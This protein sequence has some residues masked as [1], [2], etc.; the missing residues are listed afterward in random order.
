MTD[1]AWDL[2]QAHCENG[3]TE[4]IL[5]LVRTQRKLNRFQVND[6]IDTMELAKNIK[7]EKGVAFVA[8]TLS[9]T[10]D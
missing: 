6:G 10:H 3:S 4:L 1:C 2:K 8:L 9:G 7:G 5:E